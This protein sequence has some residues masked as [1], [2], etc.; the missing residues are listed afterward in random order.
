M[1]TRLR[2][3][4]VQTRLPR[5]SVQVDLH[6]DAGGFLGRADLFYP[7]ARLV[8]EY[9]GTNHRERLVEDNRRQNL[10][11]TAGYTLLRFTA[12]DLERPEFVTSQVRRA[13]AGTREFGVKAAGPGRRG[14]AFDAKHAVRDGGGK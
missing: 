12:P 5:P 13:L 6:D 1:E 4:L 8:I 11:V 7:A 9:G 2:C 14:G 3:L 10:L